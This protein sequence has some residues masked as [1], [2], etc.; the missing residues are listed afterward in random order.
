MT[1][2]RRLLTLSV[3]TALG[4]TG[5]AAPV[6]ATAA[7]KGTSALTWGACPAGSQAPRG[8][9]CST[10]KVP[11]DYAKP[12]GPQITLTLSQVG[13]RDAERT[14]VV[15]PGG[16]GQSGVEAAQPVWASMSPEVAAKY[17]VVSFDPRGVGASSPVSCG[18]A[19]KLVKHPAPDYTPADAHA[20]QARA[21][22]ARG[23]AERCATASGAL[24]DSVSTAN[25]ARDM[26]RVR[27]ALGQSK[28]DYLGYSYGSRLG[29]T[30]ATLF[31]SR[32]GRMILDGVM[33]P[34]VGDYAATYEQNPALEQR[35]RQFFAWAALNDRTYHL[36]STEAKVSATWTAVRAK[37]RTA[38]AS[39][40]AGATELDDLLASALYTDLSW[41]DLAST[42][43]DYRKGDP[44][45]LVGASK[46]L[47]AGAVDPARLAYN[48]VDDAWPRNWQTWHD[49]TTAAA[50]KAPLFA[51]MN[52]WINAP[53]AFWK[54]P[55]APP[56]KIGSVKVPPVLLLQ[57]HDDPATPLVGAQR[58]HQALSGS[59][60]VV[61]AGGNHGQYLFD[62]NACMDAYGDHYLLTGQ[63]PTADATCKASPPPTP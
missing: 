36:G 22:I 24:L 48:C 60:L 10:I 54:A 34:A 6:T 33:D 62:T 13:D 51:W 17:N 30:Y 53:C 16:P 37:L 4:L 32:T 55:T 52:T 5:L 11:L 59:R 63:L 39:G 35:T 2:T 56:V 26:D 41:P 43:A 3:A 31:P 20:E 58:M 57:S 18:D 42:V 44:S 29:A 45:S 61:A 15:N 38:P 25:A 27:E 50:K 8:T 9:Y 1:S 40:Q 19:N 46:Q 23:I 14:L 12:T 28:L 47:A 7:P 21:S 49:D